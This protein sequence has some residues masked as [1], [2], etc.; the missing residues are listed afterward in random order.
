[1]GTVVF[2]VTPSAV[3]ML[4][5]V[6][7]VA[8]TRQRCRATLATKNLDGANGEVWGLQELTICTIPISCR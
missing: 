4:Y 5:G 7:E 8:R 2:P 1:M 6:V 3:E